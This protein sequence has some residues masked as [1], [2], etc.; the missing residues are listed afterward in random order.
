M[1]EIRYYAD[2]EHMIEIVYYEAENGRQFESFGSCQEYE[3]LIHTIEDVKRIKFFDSF[4]NPLNFISETADS[5]DTSEIEQ[6]GIVFIPNLYAEEAFQEI[7]SRDNLIRFEDIDLPGMWVL[8]DFKDSENHA[9]LCKRFVWE[10]NDWEGNEEEINEF[11]KN[12]TE[13][14]VENN[15]SEDLLNKYKKILE[16][17]S[18]WG[19]FEH[20]PDEADVELS[21]EE[22]SDHR[23]KTYGFT[24]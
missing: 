21:E 12:E 22:I 23:K 10:G 14:G 15:S 13:Q 5:Y 2:D 6:A 17:Q 7:I 8:K 19:K 1:R 18:H 20:K 3:Y 9:K 11:I 16:V 4:G 24:W